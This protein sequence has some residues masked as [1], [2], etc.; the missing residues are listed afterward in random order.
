MYI[1]HPTNA[2]KT[3]INAGSSYTLN[4]L[5]TT[6]RMIADKVPIKTKVSNEIIIKFIEFFRI[7][8]HPGTKR[9]EQTF[10]YYSLYSF[11]ISKLNLVFNFLLNNERIK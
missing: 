11:L 1:S 6:N 3:Q 10:S 7:I 5:E 8:F 2:L 4:F 9:N